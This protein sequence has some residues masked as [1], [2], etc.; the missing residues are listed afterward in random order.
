MDARLQNLVVQL[1]SSAAQMQGDPICLKQ[2]L[3]NLL[4]NASKYTPEGGEI[5][6]SMEVVDSES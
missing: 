5:R 3:S 4:D 6:L 2:I 1:P